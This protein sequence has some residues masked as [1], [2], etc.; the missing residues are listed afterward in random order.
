MA[1]NTDHIFDILAWY[2]DAGVDT[3]LEDEPIDRFAEASKPPATV[4]AQ[5]HPSQR[6][7]TRNTAQRACDI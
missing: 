6:A 5:P 1:E 2:A 7:A 4:E 3:L